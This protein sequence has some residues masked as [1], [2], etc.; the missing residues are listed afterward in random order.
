MLHLWNL[1]E[2]EI[3]PLGCWGKIFKEHCLSRGTLLQNHLRECLGDAAACWAPLELIVG[4]AVN[5]AV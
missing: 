3:L 4:E 1:L 5:V 2:I